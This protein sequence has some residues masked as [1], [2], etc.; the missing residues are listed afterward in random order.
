M[1]RSG[2]GLSLGPS[3]GRRPEGPS[4]SDLRRTA[5]C[6]QGHRGEASSAPTGITCRGESRASR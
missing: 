5:S 1:G 4:L 2:W 6:T 3:G